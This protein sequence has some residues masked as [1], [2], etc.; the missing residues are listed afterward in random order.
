MFFLTSVVGLMSA[1]RSA[2]PEIS[3]QLL[4]VQPR[5]LAQMVTMN[6]SDTGDPMIPVMPL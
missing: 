1:C 4:A 5:H 3:E 6:L 2:Y